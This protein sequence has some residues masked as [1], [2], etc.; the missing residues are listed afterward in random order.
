MAR[1]CVLADA[2]TRDAAANAARHSITT[3]PV[4]FM[5][6]APMATAQR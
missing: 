2:R 6:V 4:S 5:G 3:L 1:R